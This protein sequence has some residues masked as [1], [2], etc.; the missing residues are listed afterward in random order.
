MLTPA[1]G[2]DQYPPDRYLRYGVQSDE[3]MI[4]TDNKRQGNAAAYSDRSFMPNPRRAP[5]STR[6]DFRFRD[7][8]IYTSERTCRST[9]SKSNVD[10]LLLSFMKHL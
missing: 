4:H 3:Q 2:P 5:Y 8:D 9:S 6:N 1:S 7:R 10:L